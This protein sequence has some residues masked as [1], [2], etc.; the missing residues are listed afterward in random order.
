[1][2][3]ERHFYCQKLWIVLIRN[4]LH[5]G[6]FSITPGPDDQRMPKVDLMT[7]W[8]YESTII[9]CLCSWGHTRSWHRRKCLGRHFLVTM[10]STGLSHM[11]AGLTYVTVALYDVPS[12]CMITPTHDLKK[13]RWLPTLKSHWNSVCAVVAHRLSAFMDLEP[14]HKRRAHLWHE[15]CWRCFDWVILRHRHKHSFYVF[16]K[17]IFLNLVFYLPV[18][19]ISI[20]WR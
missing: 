13:D 19:R 16:V 3:P 9:C 15:I 1:M 8:L 5:I 2:K 12:W 4:F 11:I 10:I 20:Q 6:Y 7:Y 18:S 17:R 14:L